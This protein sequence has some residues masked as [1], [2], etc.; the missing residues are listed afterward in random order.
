MPSAFAH[1]G[2]NQDEGEGMFTALIPQQPASTWLAKHR[3]SLIATILVA[4]ALIVLAV[5]LVAYWY[6]RYGPDPEDVIAF[7]QIIAWP[8]VASLAIVLFHKPLSRFLGRNFQTVK[9][10][11]FQVSVEASM[12]S[13]GEP[14]L[15]LDVARIRDM[16]RAELMSDS[17]TA[18]LERFGSEQRLDY[19]VVDIGGFK[20]PWYT[21]RLFLVAAMLER[22][23]SLRCLVFVETT[24]HEHME[25]IGTASPSEVRWRLVT[26]YPWLESSFAKAWFV[27][28]HT[29]LTHVSI[30]MDLKTKLSWSNIIDLLAVLPT[31]VKSETGRISSKEAERLVEFFFLDPNIQRPSATFDAK[32]GSEWVE[33]VPESKP[34]AGEPKSEPYWE[35]AEKIDR[36]WL[37]KLGGVLKRDDEA[38][39]RTSP[40][41]TQAKQ[42]R[43]ILRRKNAFIALVD[44]EKQFKSLVDR[45]SLMEEVGTRLLTQIDE[46]GS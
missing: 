33:V 17:R 30:K 7:A 46:V 43:A 36:I 18:I 20:P 6:S 14:E 1:R 28:Q 41:D 21:S 34:P 26:L 12:A 45:Q 35:H 27:S 13:G 10:T 19:L 22:M 32:E 38:F 8:L 4:I 39:V 24:P 2:D 31:N 16:D 29:N 44:R 37:E 5:F 11:V 42:A 9:L 3:K 15:T 23:S 25:F 40:D